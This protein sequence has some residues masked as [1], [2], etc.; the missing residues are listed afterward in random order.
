MLLSTNTLSFVEIDGFIYP[1][2]PISVCYNENKFLKQYEDLK[3]FQKKIGQQKLCPIITY[4][5]LETH[6]LIEQIDLEFQKDYVTTLQI[7]FFEECDEVNS[8]TFLYILLSKYR[9]IE[10]VSD[11]K[12]NWRWT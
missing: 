2:G 11:G 9:A 8:H 4:D 6:Y 3:F 1:K 7:R 12:K 5:K 10:V